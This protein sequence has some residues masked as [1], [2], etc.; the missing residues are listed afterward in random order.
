MARKVQQLHL[1]LAGAVSLVL[2]PML[3]SGFY[4]AWESA[5]C[6]AENPMDRKGLKEHN[7]AM[8]L[9][10][11]DVGFES[12]EELEI[13]S[14][15][16]VLVT[17]NPKHL[18]FGTW[19]ANPQTGEALGETER[20]SAL[21]RFMLTL[22]RSLFLDRTGRMIAGVCSILTLCLVIAGGV[23]WLT[24]YGR[25]LRRV[26]R[27]H[28]DVGLLSLLP[29]LFLVGTGVALSAVR[30]DVWELIPNELESVQVSHS[31]AVI[32]PSEW[33]AFQSIS[34][35]D[36]EV[37][38]Y[39]FL[40]EEDE[41]FELTMQNGDRIEF[42]A[43][44]GA[45]VALADV[46]LDEQIFAW[47][48][49][50]HTARFDGW[51]AWLWM[52]VSVAMLALAYTGLT[53]WFRRWVSA[54]RMIKHKMNDVVTDVCIVVASQMGT[55]ADRAS[56]LAKAWLEM[57]VKCTVH[58]LASFRPSPDMHKCLFM[59]ATYG[60]GDSPNR[61]QLWRKWVADYEGELTGHAAVVAF[62][63]QSYPR[64]AAFGEDMFLALNSL[65]SPKTVSLLG[66]VNRQED[67]EFEKALIELEAQWGI[68]LPKGLKKS[69]EE[70]E[71]LFNIEK[72]QKADDLAWIELKSAVNATSVHLAESGSL[73]GLIPSESKGIRWYSLSALEGGRIGM[74]VKRHEQGVCSNQIH[75]LALGDQIGASI[76]PNLNFR[77]PSSRPLAFVANGS[78]MGPFVGMIQQL[79]DDAG[80]HLF[81]GVQTRAQY[82]LI[83]EEFS[84]ALS[85]GALQSV[86]VTT[87]REGTGHKY[88]QDAVA[89]WTELPDFLTKQGTWMVCGSEAMSEGLLDVLTLK[90]N[91]SRS[92]LQNSK[93]WIED[94]Y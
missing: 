60:Q 73:L 37:L 5:L 31:E 94:C 49:R 15:G 36:V 61:H 11:L 12:V 53:S 82:D 45:V 10:R 34:L 47:T 38:R 55:T 58:D 2:L 65:N 20:R 93:S 54:R 23:L 86:I 66:K 64:F 59:L 32:A 3:V 48:D 75:G 51:L 81:W 13:T 35:K 52:A 62:G 71:V 43:T 24:L 76:Q 26:G 70:T 83:S 74:L 44:D 41:V 72:S 22:H 17:G 88:V 77:L 18:D 33:P 30:F 89:A 19:L 8:F 91:A 28:S 42:R 57:G 80:A 46:H 68:P 87:S 90:S 39:P 63:D 92:E 27:L 29:L 1:V 69:S 4:L 21:S 6:H 56:R 7:L 50:V 84:R 67:G 85:R 14:C 78:G 79:E 40:V 25:K 9:S 16:D